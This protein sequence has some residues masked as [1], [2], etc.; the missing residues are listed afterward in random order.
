[1]DLEVDLD[2]LFRQNGSYDYDNTYEYSDDSD[3][4]DS[5]EVV[6]AVLYSVEFV[7]GVLGHG[8]LLAVLAQRRRSWTISDTFIL[9]QSVADILLL[10]TLPFWAATAAQSGGWYLGGFLCKI[11][12]AL[13]NVST[14]WYVEGK[15][16]PIN[17]VGCK[18]TGLKPSCWPNA[19]KV[20]VN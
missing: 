1:M 20:K 7:V 4:K 10:F 8:L 6:I 14:E 2:G 12:G 16:G 5:L 17:E 13:C 15:G 3:S 19:V 18:W 11:S 9:H